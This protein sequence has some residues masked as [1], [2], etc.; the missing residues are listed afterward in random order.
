M[1]KHSCSQPDLG[2]SENGIASDT[3]RRSGLNRRH[4]LLSHRKYFPNLLPKE[5]GE[6]H[7]S[8]KGIGQ[9]D[10][11]QVHKRLIPGIGRDV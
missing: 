4:F 7:S 5:A 6:E 9:T 8:V 2:T 10:I 11:Q 3:G 1:G